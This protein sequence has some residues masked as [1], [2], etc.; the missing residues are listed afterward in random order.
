MVNKLLRLG[1][2]FP[3]LNARFPPA[4]SSTPLI[5]AP[6]GI[7]DWGLVTRWAQL[8]II[9]NFYLPSISK[10]Q[11][12][13]RAKLTGVIAIEVVGSMLLLNILFIGSNMSLNEFF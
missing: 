12:T 3:F 10:D 4:R 8:L 5:S 11:S 6:T 7:Y 9:S 2:M 13:M 1:S